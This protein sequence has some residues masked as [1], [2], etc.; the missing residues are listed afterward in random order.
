MVEGHLG[1]NWPIWQALVREVE[2]LGFSGLYR[3]DHYLNPQQPEQNSLELWTSLSWA[4]C[5]TRRLRLGNIVSPLSFREPTATARAA[6]S[7]H[8]LTGGRFVLGLGAGWLEA[9][10]RMFGFDL[11]SVADR[12]RRLEEGL[13]V[14]TRLLH[15]PAPASF[16]GD[17]F[18]LEEARLSPFPDGPPLLVGGNGKRRTLPLAARFA[19]EWN[20]VGLTPWQFAERSDELSALAGGRALRRSLMSGLIFGKDEAAYRKHLRGDDPEK[21]LAKG[22]VVGTPAAVCE[23]LQ[24]FAEAGVQEIMLQWLDLDDLGRLVDLRRIVD[25][26]LSS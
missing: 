18:R 7:L 10:H 15:Q 11:L 17:F 1:L 23:Q 26:V 21:A 13:E 14:I 20:G 24:A 25:P 22:A 6:A 4:A 19:Q 12:F 16:R 8:Q 9:E 2:D 5:H 3:S